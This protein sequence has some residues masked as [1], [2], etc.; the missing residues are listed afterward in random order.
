MLAIRGLCQCLQVTGF[1]KVKKGQKEKG[2]SLCL[3][4]AEF[5]TYFL[6]RFLSCWSWESWFVVLVTILLMELYFSSPNSWPLSSKCK[7]HLFLARYTA[8]L[9]GSL[10]VIVFHMIASSLIWLGRRLPE[11]RYRRASPPKKW[12]RFVRNHSIML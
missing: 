4:L 8:T 12:L 2:S 9:R 5:K 11:G 3:T 7:P 10:T 6:T 1:E